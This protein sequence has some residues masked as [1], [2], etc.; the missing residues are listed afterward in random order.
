ML[1]HILIFED[2]DGG[3]KP[4]GCCRR[5]CKVERMK[6]TTAGDHPS[7]PA[8][9]YTEATDT[10]EVETPT[11]PATTAYRRL[12][13]L[14]RPLIEHLRRGSSRVNRVLV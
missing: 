4:C 12:D 3:L 13:P 2:V 8:L 10:A 14:I 11:V 6:T 5:R 9:W 7:E 1:A